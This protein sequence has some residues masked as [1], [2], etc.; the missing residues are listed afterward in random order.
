MDIHQA[1]TETVQEII[2]KMDAHQ[3]RMGASTNAWRKE[4]TACQEGMEA[5]LESKEPSSVEIE[6][7]AVH[8]EVPEEN[9]AVKTVKST[10]EAV[11]GPASRRSAQPTA[12]E[13]DPGHW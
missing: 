11:W 5:C 4:P 3:E 8:E 6:P 9:A 1:R 13:T 7:V 2:A 12:A 10:E